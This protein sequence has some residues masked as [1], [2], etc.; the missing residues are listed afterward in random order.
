MKIIYIHQYFVT[1]SQGGGTRSYHLAKGMVEAGIE[2]EMITSHSENYYD[3]KLIDGIKVHYLPVSYHQE[4]GFLK[5]IWAFTAFVDQSKKLLLKLPRPDF[6]YI[7][8][9]PLTTGWIGLWAKRKLA[10]PFFFEVRDLWPDAPIQVGVIQNPILKKI[11]YSLESKIYKH[12]YKVIA[13]SPG[14]ANSI[15]EKCNFCKIQLIPNFAD[16]DFFQPMEKKES[17]LQ[18]FGLKPNL[19]IAYA[20][21]IGQVNAVHEML[22]LA[23][24]AQ[25]KSKDY[26]FVV[27]GKGALTDGLLRLAKDLKLD[28]FFYFPFGSK[29]EVRQLLSV[30]DLSFVSFAHLPVLKTNSPNKFFDALAAGKG[31]IVNHKGWVFQLV[32]EYQLG[33]YF[34]PESPDQAFRKLEKMETNPKMLQQTQK[35]SR[36]LAEKFFSKEIAV[37]R[38]LDVIDPDKFGKDFRDEVYILTA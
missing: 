17:F 15:R 22:I 33:F 36:E 20:G 18:K 6:L 28:N 7:T 10:I 25:D 27:M 1:P 12:A 13:L 3:F 31:I 38:L 4:Y 9:T 16:T 21:A 5:R 32:Q 23:K 34:N 29:E 19:T 35:N 26:Q 2:V 11:L 14:I 24:M 30:S 37:Q 8:S